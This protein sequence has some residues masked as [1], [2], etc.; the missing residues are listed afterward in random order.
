MPTL[1]EVRKE[2]VLPILRK[3]KEQGA[4]CQRM[5]AEESDL[6][7]ASYLA[8][9]AKGMEIIESGFRSLSERLVD[10]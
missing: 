7:K 10:E 2:L 4:S 8:G 1:D 5:A 3:I 9:V 6:V